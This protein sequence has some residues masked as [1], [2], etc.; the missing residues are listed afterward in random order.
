M[1]YFRFYR[2]RVCHSTKENSL[3]LWLN[4][5]RNWSCRWAWTGVGWKAAFYRQ[6]AQADSKYTDEI[7]AKYNAIHQPVL[8]LWGEED[9][10]NWCPN[11]KH[12]K[13]RFYGMYLP[14]I[15]Y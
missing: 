11:F 5:W 10:R 15:K 12:S 8:I 4:A 2:K 6:I 7:Q 3:R 1:T 13:D 14:T 9:M